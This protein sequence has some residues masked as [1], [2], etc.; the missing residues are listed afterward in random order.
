M[1]LPR[2]GFPAMNPAL[3]TQSVRFRFGVVRSPPRLPDT[4]D[5]SFLIRPTSSPFGFDRA[6][7]VVHKC[8]AT[9]ISVLLVDGCRTIRELSGHLSQE[10]RVI[11]SGDE[12]RD[13][14]RGT[15]CEPSYQI[16]QSSFCATS[17]TPPPLS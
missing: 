7:T 9:L 11:E 13:F 4:G 14:G 2:R 16:V 12:K 10:H 5:V 3:L 17:L 6:M 15:L 1:L 8:P